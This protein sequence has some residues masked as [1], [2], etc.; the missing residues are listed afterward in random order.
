MVG[1]PDT[2]SNDSKVLREI[3]IN[4]ILEAFN[5]AQQQINGLITQGASLLSSV[6]SMSASL[7][8]TINALGI[9]QTTV[10]ENHTQVT[11][12]I[13]SLQL[14]IDDTFARISQETQLRISAIEA[15]V[16]N[17]YNL[18]VEIF[19]SNARIRDEQF[20][21]VTADEALA[22]TISTMEVEFNDSISAAI[23]TEAT[24]RATADSALSSLITAWTVGLA[25]P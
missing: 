5:A 21:R 23:T 10:Q 6:T 24:T 2:F 12:K 8:N 7:N 18:E 25:V 11:T 3:D 19:G 9:V 15:S 1:S 16:R 20:A 22:Y 14:S 4:T 13:S 17:I